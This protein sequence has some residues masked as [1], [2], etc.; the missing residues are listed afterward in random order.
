VASGAEQ[1]ADALLAGTIATAAMMAG[2]MRRALELTVGYLCERE[3]FGVP[4]GAFQALQH[5]VARLHCQAMLAESLVQRA[6]HALDAHEPAAPRRVHA[7]KAYV[8]DTYLRVAEEGV[9][10]HGGIGMTDEIEI[11][12]HLAAARVAELE[13]GAASFHRRRYAEISGY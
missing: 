8:S 11:G 7:A 9:Q 1:L 4:I 5:R 6:L 13:F 12:Y 3:Q 10:M 2:G